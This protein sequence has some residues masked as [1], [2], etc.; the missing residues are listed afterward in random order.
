MVSC[1][2]AKA[3]PPA[4][5]G[6]PSINT[7][8]YYK[9]GWIRADS[10]NIPALRDTNWTP[11][12]SG[13]SVFWLHAGVDT[14]SWVWD[15]SHW[16]RGGGVSSFNGRSGNVTLLSSDVS[17][18]LGYN[19]LA[20]IT[21]YIQAGSNVT[22]TGL[23]TLASPYVVNSSGG[24]GGGSVT[25][26]SFTNGNGFTGVVTNA[27]STPTLSLG[28]SLTGII[29]GNGTGFGTVGIGSGLSYS[30][31]VLSATGGTSLNGLVSANGSSFTT[32]SIGAGLSFSGNTLV[33]T[34]NNT[35][36]LTNGSGFISNITGLVTAGTNVTVTGAGTSGSPYVINSSGSGSGTVTTFSAGNLSPLFTTSVTNPNTI[37]AL[38]FTLTPAAANSVFGNN[39]G[40]TGAPLYYVPTITTLNGWASGSIALL[41]VANTFTALQTFG[42]LTTTGVTKMT[43]LASGG[44][45]DSVL[46]INTST[47]QLGFTSRLFTISAVQGTHASVTGDSVELGGFFFQP[48]TINTFG[49]GFAITNLPNEATLGVGD[50]VLVEKAGS[51]YLT[52][53]PSSAIGG[54]GAVSSVSDDG[55]STM[56]ISPT[57]GAVLVGLNLANAN[58]WTGNITAN[59]VNYLFGT[60]AAST[61]GDGTNNS[62]SVNTHQVNSNNQ[63]LFGVPSGQTYQW[64]IAG[65]A[66]MAL[67]STGQLRLNKYLLTTS[68][69]GTGIGVL[70]FDASGNIVTAAIPSGGTQTLQ[71]VFAVQA[72]NAVL[73]SSDTVSGSQI[74][75]MDN[76]K[77]G[78]TLSPTVASGGSVGTGAL[79]YL[80]VNASSFASPSSVTLSALTGNGLSF[81][82]GSTRFQISATG[83]EVLPNYTATSS[84]PITAVGMLV[85]DA[86]GNIGTAAIPGGGG[87]GGIGVD[88]VQTDT[89]SSGSTLT[90]TSGYNELVINPSSII[91]SLTLT[92]ATV[93]HSSND[94]YI[95][96]G[97]GT[98]NISS[99][100]VVT[101]FFLVG[102]AGLTIVTSFNPNG[103]TYNWGDLLKLHKVGS[104]LYLTHS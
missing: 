21:N 98:G 78:G 66:N 72:N 74:V 13:T 15:G 75:F 61:V 10:G 39:T 87:G 11:R 44:A 63:L 7:T 84:F 43:G 70:E 92:T 33:N 22:I 80:T 59:G 91:S 17:G 9:I 47:G 26:F 42:T 38:G 73:T 24:G 100:P 37:P 20:N 90:Q 69:S 53:V 65:T 99:G 34:I 86:S 68:F 45:N 96:F 55:R 46:T 25:S 16:K 89:T 52:L 29:S 97:G 93:F 88:S 102:G 49:F 23:G 40:S 2:V 51:K 56:T 5:A 104:T 19:P 12:F 4:P 77:T 64:N 79:P 6:F 83:Q 8:G 101:A 82:N 32:A 18:A 31:G 28:T 71:Q 60:N 30:G 41:G 57:T 54:G 36:Q 27:T 58:T 103:A 81:G 48:D 1:V 3:Q 35:N 14:V 67:L 50:S 85:F 76:V 94:L 62:L 95:R